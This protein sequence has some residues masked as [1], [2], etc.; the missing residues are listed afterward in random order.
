MNFAILPFASSPGGFWYA[1]GVMALSV[2]LLY[3]YFKHND[4]I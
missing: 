1:L 4:W 2:I 3:S